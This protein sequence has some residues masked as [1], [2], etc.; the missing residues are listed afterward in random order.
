MGKSCLGHAGERVEDE[1]LC[2]L[3]F[4]MLNLVV[5]SQ[6]NSLLLSCG[7]GGWSSWCYTWKQH[8]CWQ[9]PCISPKLRSSPGS[10]AHPQLWNKV[11][12]QT[13]VYGSKGLCVMP[14]PKS[15]SADLLFLIL[16]LIQKSQKYLICLFILKD[17]RT[18]LCLF[19]RWPCSVTSFPKAGKV[20][21]T[22]ISGRILKLI[23][24]STLFQLL[25]I[26]MNDINSASPCARNLQKSWIA[27]SLINR[28][29]L[30]KSTVWLQRNSS[31]IVLW[32]W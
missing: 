9:P 21:V 27:S 7:A 24:I 1:V 25:K 11:R 16:Y 20:H 2:G 4:S 12:E 29:L 32:K 5:S 28:D 17:Q 23:P 30:M 31:T 14:C 3:I 6:D 15:V 18:W 19:L 26:W 10:W 13:I 22:V 8:S